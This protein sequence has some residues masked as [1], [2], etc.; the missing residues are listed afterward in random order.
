MGIIYRNLPQIPIP[1]FAKINGYDKRVSVYSKVNG[2]RTRMLIGVAISPTTMQPND[3]FRVY[4]PELW[5]E[6]YTSDESGPICYQ[7]GMYALTYGI[8]AGQTSLYPLLIESVGPEVANIILDYAMYG[9]IYRSNTATCFQDFMAD[10]LLFNREPASDR[11]LSH[12][13]NNEITE[14]Q[15]AAFIEKWLS[16]MATVC[17]NKTVCLSI[18]TTNFDDSGRISEFPNVGHSKSA[19]DLPAIGYVYVVDSESGRPLTWHT[20]NGDT[21]DCKTLNACLERVEAYGFKA[22]SVILDQAFANNDVMEFI[23]SKGLQYIIKLKENTS[24]TKELID[25]FRDDLWFNYE[26]IIDRDCTF[27]ITTEAKI[28]S[29]SSSSDCLAI[30]FNGEMFIN[31]MKSTFSQAYKY[32]DMVNEHIANKNSS[33]DLEVSD[34]LSKQF[35]KSGNIISVKVDRSQLNKLGKTQGFYVIAS[36]EHMSAQDIL[37]R[38]KLKDVSEKVFSFIKTQFGN[39]SMPVHRDEAVESKLFLRFILAVIRTEIMLLCQQ[40]NVDTSLLIKQMCHIKAI[41]IKS[42]QYVFQQNIPAPAQ[43][44]LK[45]LNVSNETFK[46]LVDELNN[47]NTCNSPYRFIALGTEKVV[48]RGRP[49]GSLNKA[50]LY[51][52]QHSS[53][54]VEEK[55]PRGR[56]KGRTQAVLE[57]EA[58]KV[59][60]PKGRPKGIKNKKTLEKEALEQAAKELKSRGIGRPKGRKNKKTLEKEALLKATS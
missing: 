36:S 10:K 46:L 30:Y 43:K 19:N 56:P 48:K 39:D 12:V 22:E 28:F 7:M 51:K 60:K 15:Q 20:F 16:Y 3:N 41:A 11:R 21:P 35:D 57:R 38:Y 26:N 18:A 49:K 6:Y 40:A 24:S 1:S 5:A 37:E 4:F 44:V 17:E 45:L 33:D 29:R 8:C 27:G 2:K 13:F 31:Q 25:A 32:E 47:T 54:Q 9:I 55:R 42:N 50:T 59:P 34:L 23:K 52:M 58:Q 53:A 14:K